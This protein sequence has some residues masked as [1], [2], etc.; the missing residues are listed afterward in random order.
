[1]A[2]FEPAVL[3]EIELSEVGRYLAP[4]TGRGEG[5]VRGGGLKVIGVTL[6]D[7]AVQIEAAEPQLGRFVITFEGP[8]VESSNLGYD[9]DEETSLRVAL[10]R[11]LRGEDLWMF[12]RGTW[13]VQDHFGHHYGTIWPTVT[14]REP[15]AADGAEREA[16][17]EQMVSDVAGTPGG[18]A[19]LAYSSIVGH[20]SLVVAFDRLTVHTGSAAAAKGA[21]PGCGSTHF[22]LTA[23]G[24][25]PL[26]V[27]DGELVLETT[28]CT[29]EQLVARVKI[30]NVLANVKCKECGLDHPGMGAMSGFRFSGKLAGQEWS[31]DGVGRGGMKLSELLV[32]DE[33]D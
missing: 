30:T 6:V 24:C 9:F 18:R 28:I 20:D 33:R 5:W 23:Q 26:E 14:N 4:F 21:C 13:E 15:L 16:A 31:A 17:F 3:V 22:A 12:E 7:S 29:A 19:H 27:V 25:V 2:T 1:M 11:A 32:G 10:P 8:S